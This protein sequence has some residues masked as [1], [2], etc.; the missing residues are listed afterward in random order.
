MLPNMQRDLNKEAWCLNHIT[1]EVF[2]QGAID[3]CLTVR[4]FFKGEALARNMANF[5]RNN[6]VYDKWVQHARE[7][8]QAIAFAKEDD[9]ERM[10]TC[11]PRRTGLFQ[12]RRHHAQLHGI[13][14]WRNNL[15][16][17]EG[18]NS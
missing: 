15:V 1:S 7:L 10:D 16:S 2:Y 4:G 11:Q 8:E 5:G 12:E 9:Y 17:N 18:M 13:Q 6:Q 3:A 14:R